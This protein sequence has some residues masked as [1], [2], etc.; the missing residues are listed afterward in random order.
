MIYYDRFGHKY[1]TEKEV[2]APPERYLDCIKGA[3]EG[4]VA[5]EYVVCSEPLKKLKFSY[6][7]NELIEL[8]E[9]VLD[10]RRKDF[11]E[12]NDARGA[13]MTA[14]ILPPAHYERYKEEI[15]KGGEG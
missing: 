15:E 14:F 2:I 1:V 8:P 4:V 11:L 7:E 10:Q 9:R 3:L 12:E 5:E 6:T 13:R